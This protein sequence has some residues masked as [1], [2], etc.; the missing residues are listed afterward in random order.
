MNSIIELVKSGDFA[1]VKAAL[2]G[3]ANANSGNSMGW[4]PLH[5]AARYNLYDICKILIDNGANVNAA[6]CAGWTPLHAACYEGLL[7]ICELLID[8]GADVNIEDDEGERPIDEAVGEGHSVIVK[9]LCS[10]GAFLGDEKSGGNDWELKVLPKQFSVEDGDMVFFGEI[11]NNSGRYHIRFND[12]VF[13]RSFTS[14]D[15]AELF[16][17]GLFCDE[18]VQ[19]ETQPYEL[20]VGEEKVLFVFTGSLYYIQDYDR[21]VDTIPCAIAY[22]LGAMERDKVFPEVA[23]R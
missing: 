16:V 20:V 5:W 19:Y 21:Y 13:G 18:D 17:E 23:K 7:E 2:E 3:G 4:T 9:F 15:E 1:G 11:I 22:I 10:R 8:S 12:L 6:N 14:S